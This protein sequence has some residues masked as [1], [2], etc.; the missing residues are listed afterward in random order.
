MQPSP[1]PLATAAPPVT[2]DAGAPLATTEPAERETATDGARDAGSGPGSD[3]PRRDAGARSWNGWRDANGCRIAEHVECPHGARCN[4]PRPVAFPCPKEL[5]T[6]APIFSLHGDPE[7]RTCTLD[8]MEHTSSPPC[9]QGALCNPPPPR[10][11]HA[12]VDCPK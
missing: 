5:G 6:N 10:R 4:P 9:P 8:A 7:T 3:T 12:T 1:A 11:I 2:S